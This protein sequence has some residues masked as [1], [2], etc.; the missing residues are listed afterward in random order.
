MTG[1][2]LDQAEWPSYLEALHEIFEDEE[3]DRH[4]AFLMVVERDER[5]YPDV[6]KWSEYYRI[7]MRYVQAYR[8][9]ETYVVV[10]SLFT[11]AAG[12]KEKAASTWAKEFEDIMGGPEAMQE[13][14]NKISPTNFEEEDEVVNIW[15]CSS[16]EEARADTRRLA[17]SWAQE[18]G[19]NLIAWTGWGADMVL[20][21]GGDANFYVFR[22]FADGTTEI[23]K[24]EDGL[25]ASTGYGDSVGKLA[26]EIYVD[27]RKFGIHD[28]GNPTTGKVVEAWLRREAADAMLN[29][30]RASLR[31]RMEGYDKI[32]QV[33]LED[34]GDNGFVGNISELARKLHT[35]RANLYRLMPSRQGP[36]KRRR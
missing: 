7:G 23:D 10:E 3:D 6:K 2:L 15:S 21:V 14:L 19:R 9:N 16:E 32:N 26:D 28:M 5:G 33:A 31:V 17:L 25:H 1:T 34:P 35:D 22:T 29:A 11:Q 20:F 36:R 4:D 8:L 30:A 27:P 18:S 13:W 12:A 24:Y